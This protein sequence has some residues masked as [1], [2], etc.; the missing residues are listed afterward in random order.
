MRFDPV[1]PT[2]AEPYLPEGQYPA[3][4]GG[5]RTNPGYTMIY[6][7]TGWPSAVVRAGTSPDGLPIGIQMIAQPWN[8]HVSLAAASYL[9]AKTGGWQKPPI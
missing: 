1:H 9:E 5:G 6:N 7:T 2:P 3:N 4:A 8:E